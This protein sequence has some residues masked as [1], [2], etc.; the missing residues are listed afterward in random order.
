MTIAQD[1]EK[2]CDCGAGHGS[3]EGHVE[4]C[5]WLKLKPRFEAA[6]AAAELLRLPILEKIRV[7]GKMMDREQVAAALVADQR[8]VK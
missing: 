2:F 7:S 6:I 3:L 4:W 1:E 5:A 8:E